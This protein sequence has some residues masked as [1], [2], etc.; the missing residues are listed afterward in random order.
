ME[1]EKY[2]VADDQKLVEMA[3]E[4]DMVALEQLFNRYRAGITQLYIQRTGG[5]ADDVEDLVQEVFIKVYLNLHRYNPEYTFGQWVYTIA[6]N[7]FIDYVRK[8][9]DDIS[10]DNIS[11]GRSNFTPQ[12]NA[13]SPEECVINSQQHS[14][15]EQHLVKMA[16]RYRKLIELR[17]FKDYSY[18]EIATELGKPLGTIKTQ[19]HRAR[20]QL[21]KLITEKTDILS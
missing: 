6:R 12:A 16:P 9:R 11:D 19:I 1:I 5:K 13:P 3:L 7:A 14:Q 17:F 18:E 20:E 2:I 4:S 15:L 8:R 10:I 21:C